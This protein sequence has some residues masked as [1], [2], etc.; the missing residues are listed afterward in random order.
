MVA[1]HFVW[2][3]RHPGFISPP[4]WVPQIPLHAD[5]LL[6]LEDDILAPFDKGKFVLAV[7]F[8]LQ[9]EYDTTWK[10]GVFA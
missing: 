4:I 5:L 7:F 9:Q 1:E 3:D 10:R 6:H 2:V 8:D